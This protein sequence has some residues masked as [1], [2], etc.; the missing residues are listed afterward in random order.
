M[1]ATIIHNCR[2]AYSVRDGIFDCLSASGG[3][4]YAVD[5]EEADEANSEFERAEG[6]DILGPVPSA[7]SAPSGV[8]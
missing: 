8:E 1:Y 2:P 4:L 5:N 6:I 3:H 7:P